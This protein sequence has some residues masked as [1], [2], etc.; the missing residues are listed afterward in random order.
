MGFRHTQV[1]VAGS[2]LHVIE[3]GDPEASPFLFLHGWP[4]SWQSW[5]Q[6]MTMASSQVRAIAIDLPG[7]GDSTW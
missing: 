4:E 2:S 6:I 1:A 7:N 5:R 3:A